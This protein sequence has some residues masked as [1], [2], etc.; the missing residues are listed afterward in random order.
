MGKLVKNTD[1][2]KHMLV[3]LQRRSSRAGVTFK[4]VKAHVGWAGNEAADVR[5]LTSWQK[6]GQS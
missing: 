6:R 1:L 4:H 3:L 2:I 5:L